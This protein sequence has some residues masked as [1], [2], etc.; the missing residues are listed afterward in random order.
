MDIVFGLVIWR[1][2][3]VLPRPSM[4][5]PE[6]DNV[7]EMLA[8]E[9]AGFVVPVL[10]ILIVTVYWL[11][12]NAM[13]SK[14]KATD[15]VHT[16]ISIF[17]MF[18]ILFYLYALRLGIEVGSE[19]DTRVL[20]SCAATL[21]GATAFLGWWYAS[22]R[23]DLVSDEITPEEAAKF[24]ESN[25]AEPLTALLTIPAAFIG[26]GAWE[27]S[28]FLYPLLKKFFGRPKPRQAGT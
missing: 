10:A 17:Q 5:N 19:A 22:T 12:N 15:S 2:F 3:T 7:A 27:M 1:I 20:E 6:W 9:W 28:W 26:P 13:F 16:G 25:L 4:D 21:V 24:R 11:Q 14:L 8:S 18:F 23:A